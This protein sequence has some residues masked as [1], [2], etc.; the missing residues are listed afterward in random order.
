M[1]IYER[2]QRTQVILP[3]LLRNVKKIRNTRW[4]TSVPYILPSG[5]RGVMSTIVIKP[6]SGSGCDQVNIGRVDRAGLCSCS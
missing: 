6:P 1:T 4:G 2:T 3:T 5:K